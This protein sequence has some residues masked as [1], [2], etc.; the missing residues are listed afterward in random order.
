MTAAARAVQRREALE[1]ANARRKDVAAARRSLRSGE[2]SL[3]DV[4]VDRPVSL[5]TAPLVD[6]IRWAYARRSPKA[7]T[8]IGRAAVRDRVNLLIP[9]GEASVVSRAWVAEHGSYAWQAGA[10]RRNTA[11]EDPTA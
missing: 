3:S 2:L 5:R 4:M 9:L 6:V 11:L 7:L 10:K 1:M 8:M